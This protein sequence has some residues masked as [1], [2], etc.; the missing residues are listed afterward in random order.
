MEDASSKA[1]VP[2]LD[3]EYDKSRHREVYLAHAKHCFSL[4]AWALSDNLVDEKT[5]FDRSIQDNFLEAGYISPI[6]H[7]H[8]RKQLTKFRTEHIAQ[9]KDASATGTLDGPE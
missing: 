3:E 8:W 6:L 2:I 9:R 5:L 1:N 7:P 4:Y